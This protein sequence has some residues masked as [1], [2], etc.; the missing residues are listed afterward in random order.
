M[1]ELVQAQDT[2]IKQTRAVVEQL[3]KAVRK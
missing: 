2:L 1:D 3:K